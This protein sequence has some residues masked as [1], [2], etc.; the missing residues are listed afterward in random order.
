MI[1]AGD[2][3]RLHHFDYGDIGM[4][5]RRSQD[6]GKTWGDKLTISN[7]RDNPEATDKTAYITP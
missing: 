4:V 7:L 1:A 3:R 2:E 6:N 5:I